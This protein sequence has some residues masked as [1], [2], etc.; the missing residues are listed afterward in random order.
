MNPPHALVA[1]AGIGGLCTSLCLARGGWRV[2]L[3]EKAKVLEETGAGLQLSPNASAILG[4]LG[5]IGRLTPF[6][7]RPKA[8]RFRRARDGATLAVMPLDDAERRWGA[9]YLVVH[10][11]DLQRAL[12]EAIAREPSIKLQT[13]AAVAGFASGSEGV[14]VAIEQGTVRLKAAGDC[15]IGAD[16]VRSFVRQRLGADSARFS[17]RTAWRAIVAASHVPAELRRDETNLWLGRKAHLVHYP[18]RGGAI[19]NVVAIV[20]ENCC[21]DGADFWSSLGERGF[22]EA[23]FSGW[24]EAARNLLHAAPDW[25]KWPLFDCNPIASWV[26]GRVA[27]MGD[28]AHPM[29]P[30]LAQGAAQAI[31]DAGALGEVLA[32]GQNIEASLRAYQEMR[33]PRATRVQKESRRQAK[34][35]HLAGPAALLRD[36][37][38]RAL[39]PQKMLARYDWLFD[40]HKANLPSKPRI[41]P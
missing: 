4:R 32:R 15:L 36:M 26:A 5:V 6:A 23:R 14:A 35:Y 11:A 12:L 18:L 22:L 38:L 2:S 39:G 41:N 13:G 40:T 28:A 25:R 20:D 31:E 33:C 34:I 1:G 30:F 29:L 37:A 19:I 7:L 9:P 3:Y 16:G 17:G 10:R 24:D 8:I 21:P 27:L